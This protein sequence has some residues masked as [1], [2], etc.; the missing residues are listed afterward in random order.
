M[1][2]TLSEV[3]DDGIEQHGLHIW[4]F[5]ELPQRYEQ[6]EADIPLKLILR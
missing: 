2:E 1:Q 6:K 4:S 5:G 3:V